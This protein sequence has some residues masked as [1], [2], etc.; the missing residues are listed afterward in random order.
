MPAAT[1][2]HSQRIC[3]VWA[4]NLDEEMKKI[5]QVIRKYNYVAMVSECLMSVYQNTA[6]ILTSAEFSKST[7]PFKL[8]V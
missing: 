4:C 6:K 2:D 1:V 7:H 8:K 3:E 5:R